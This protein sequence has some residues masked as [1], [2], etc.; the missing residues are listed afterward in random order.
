MASAMLDFF[1][2][3]YFYENCQCEQRHVGY[4]DIPNSITPNSER[5]SPNWPKQAKS[6][7]GSSKALKVVINAS[8]PRQ[9]TNESLISLI[10]YRVKIMS[11]ESVVFV[12]GEH[13]IIKTTAEIARKAGKLSMLMK[14]ADNLTLRFLSEGFIS[15][16]FRGE[17][18]VSLQ[19][20]TNEEVH[21]PAETVVGYLIMSPFVH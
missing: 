14:P 2:K 6:E 21:L 3:D 10:E 19:N 8:F 13:K 11:A 4:C 18:S 7:I 16:S 1:D 5:A 9:P 20:A 15:P 12:P 17:I